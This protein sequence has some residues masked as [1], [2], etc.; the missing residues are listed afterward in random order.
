[1]NVQVSRNAA[2]ATRATCDWLIRVLENPATRNIMVAGGNTPLAL[3]AEVAR[4]RPNVGHLRVFALDEYVGVPPDEPRNCAN[5]LRRSVVATWNIPAE[6]YHYLS[7]AEQ[8]AEDAIRDHEHKIAAAGGLHLVILGLGRNGHVGFNEPGSSADCEGRVVQLDT[9]SI[10]A[11]REWFHG[12]FAPGKGVTTGMKTL[13][14]SR[15]ALVLA[16]GSAKAEAVAAM[17]EGAQ[18][19]ACPASFLQ[20]HPNARF[21]LDEDAAAR[22]RRIK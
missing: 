1:M 2:E 20:R 9:V 12:R 17:L 19:E 7:S 11:N 5:L 8:G 4:R 22:L 13:L 6:Q 15:C 3:Y 10:E 18:T 14:A 16:F 21:V